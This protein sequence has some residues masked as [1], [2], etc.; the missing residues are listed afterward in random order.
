MNGITIMMV[1]PLSDVFFDHIF[2]AV[3]HKRLLAANATHFKENRPTYAVHRAVM[4]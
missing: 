2:R 3:D 4:Q 1:S